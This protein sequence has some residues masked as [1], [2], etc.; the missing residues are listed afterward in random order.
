MLF[1][2]IDQILFNLNLFKLMSLEKGKKM[3]NNLS[4]TLVFSYTVI[5]C[6]HVLV[7]AV[8]FYQQFK[9]DFITGV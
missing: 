8:F 4:S 6:S 3:N 5:C 9:S 2:V 7:L 1:S